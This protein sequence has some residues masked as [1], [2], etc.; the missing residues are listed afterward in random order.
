MMLFY[1]KGLAID[2]QNDYVSSELNENVDILH[3][4]LTSA[5]NANHGDLCRFDRLYIGK[6]K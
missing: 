2:N 6:D 4:K 3:N 1:K 5:M